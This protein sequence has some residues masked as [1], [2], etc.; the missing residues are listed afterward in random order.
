[1]DTTLSA[2]AVLLAGLMV[3]VTLL[4]VAPLV[5]G[6]ASL[7]PLWLGGML[8]VLLMVVT[9]GTWL[10]VQRP[11]GLRWLVR[12]GVGVVLSVPGL[13]RARWVPHDPERT[14]TRLADHILLL[15]PR[16]VT[17]WLL[18]VSTAISTWALDYLTLVACLAA[19][20]AAV[21]WLAAAV[22]YIAV[23]GSIALQLTPAG[24]GP[25]EAGLL[26]ALLAGGVA[27]GAAAVTVV[28]FR[29][30]TVLG[31]AVVG[32]GVFVYLAE[33]RALP[34]RRRAETAKAA[35]LGADSPI[36]D[37]KGAPQREA[38]ATERPTGEQRSAGTG[39]RA[40]DQPSGSRTDGEYAATSGH[41]PGRALR[42]V[43]NA[44]RARKAR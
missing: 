5:F 14:A 19:T 11:T 30:I 2:W 39:Q 4:V 35:E 12:R 36:E 24:T 10:I 32:W 33:R 3:S 1:V 21:P 7:V 44:A 8:S 40:P 31:L 20:G 26:A 23:Q 43:A 9:L 18:L 38:P 41:S 16:G 15:R 28:L 13:R 6:A 29:G 37:Q 25:A 17:Q 42:R 22:G 34:A 27:P